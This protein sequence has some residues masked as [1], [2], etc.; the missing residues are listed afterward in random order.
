MY[1]LFQTQNRV[2][3]KYIHTGSVFD[4]QRRLR[5]RHEKNIKFMAQ[6]HTRAQTQTHNCYFFVIVTTFNRRYKKVSSFDRG[7]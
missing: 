1:F 5:G 7:V 3:L 2:H 4:T 6:M